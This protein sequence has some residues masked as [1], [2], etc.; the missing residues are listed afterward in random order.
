MESTSHPRVFPASKSPNTLSSIVDVLGLQEL[1]PG[2]GLG[3]RLDA[4]ETGT[5]I[6]PHRR[7]EPPHKIVLCSH[8]RAIFPGEKGS[9]VKPPGAQWSP[10]E[11]LPRSGM[12]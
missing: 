11:S 4:S 3:G 1:A 7:N 9:F 6:H 12:I 8:A 2:S 5:V 10:D